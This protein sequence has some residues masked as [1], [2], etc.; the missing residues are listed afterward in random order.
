LETYGRDV[1]LVD[2]SPINLHPFALEGFRTVVGDATQSDT[3]RFAGVD[4]TALV[5]VCVP[6]DDSAMQT[7]RAIRR[8]NRETRVIV[9]CRFHSNESK[10]RRAGADRVVSEETVASMALLDELNRET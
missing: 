3:L 10:L 7:V 4:Q 9:R 1:C 6:D 5:A 8:L 2:L